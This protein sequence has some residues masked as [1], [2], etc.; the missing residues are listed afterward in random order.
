MKKKSKPKRD[1]AFLFYC[2]DAARDVSHMN[3]L[4]RGAYFDLIQAQQ[5]FGGYT[6]EQARKILGSDFEEVW[7][8]LEWILSKDQEGKFFIDW[9]RNSIEERKE[10]AEEQR[11]RIQKYWDNKKREAEQKN[12]STEIPRNNHGS[13][14]DIP[15]ED[16]DEDENENE[17]EINIGKEDSKG[18]KGKT[19]SKEVKY[20][21]QKI[22]ALY[23]SICPNLP[24]VL[25]ITD[26]RKSAI[27][28]C[29]DSVRPDDVE[30]F[31]SNFF[32]KVAESDILNNRKKGFDFTADFDFVFTK[33][34]FVK[35]LEGSYDNISKPNGPNGAPV[36]GQGLPASYNSERESLMKRRTA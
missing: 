20:P 32:T 28:G 34:K 35:I 19:N 9:M 30:A 25:V 12:N 23:H 6:A 13:T 26:K 31:L 16:E 36:A 29:L 17:R 7:P 2:G 4:E 11:K 14:V 1:P 22:V 33:S 3:R 18:G 8:A 15:L 10:Y 21:Y 27:N 5:K 24:R